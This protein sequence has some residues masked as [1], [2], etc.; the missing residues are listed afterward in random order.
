MYHKK[1]IC[2]SCGKEKYIFSHGKCLDCCKPGFK[3]IVPKKAKIQD[4][5]ILSQSKT[6]LKAFKEHKGK[7]FING[8][9]FK[10]RHIKAYNFLHVLRKGKYQYFKY[11]SKNIVLGDL[12]Q[13]KL[14]DDGTM[15]DIMKLRIKTGKDK[16][17]GWVRLFNLQVELKKEY[18]EWVRYNKGEYKL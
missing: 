5:V 16:M 11:Y 4:N 15:D 17:E 6:F 3:K 13:H 2:K 12:E 8:T 10:L 7:N 18:E 1:K 14:F 9:Q